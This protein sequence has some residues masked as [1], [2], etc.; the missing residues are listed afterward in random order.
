MKRPVRTAFTLLELLVVTAILGVLV[1]LLL[2]A[3]QR[4]RAAAGRAQCAN[5]LRQLGVALHNYHGS[6]AALPPGNVA[7]RPSNPYPFAGWPTFVLP[8]IEQEAVWGLV[9]AAYAANPYFATPPHD[10]YKA[11]PQKLFGCPA[12]PRTPGPTTRYQKPGGP[13]ALTAYLGV[14]GQHATSEDGVLY[15]D[16]KVRLTDIS[17]G[18]SSTLMAGER[19]PDPTEEMGWCYAGVGQLSTGSLDMVLGVRE[20]NQQTVLQAAKC[21][22][23]PYHFG[24]GRVENICDAF[25]FWSLHPG[26]ANFLFADGSVRFLS[27]HA[28]SILPALATRAGG[29]VVTLPD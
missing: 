11:R 21:W 7:N 13:F 6:R 17:D 20:T 23:G 25:H 29:E 1:A 4:A 22:P 5:N 14:M 15:S 19:P 12:D 28:D 26:G 10:T 27:Y 16:S 2:A 9:Q 8:Y 24:P 18:T 3:V